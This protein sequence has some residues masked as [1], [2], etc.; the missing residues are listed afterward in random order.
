MC[1]GVKDEFFDHSSE[2]VVDHIKE[3]LVWLH[4]PTTVWTVVSNEDDMGWKTVYRFNGQE[5]DDID[6]VYE[7][8]LD[9]VQFYNPFQ[10]DI[11]DAYEDN[12]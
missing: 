4:K 7:Y 1:L 6:V 10:N 12:R 3:F 9:N 8:W 5:T 2:M 11:I